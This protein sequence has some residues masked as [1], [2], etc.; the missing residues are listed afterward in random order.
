MA[1]TKESNSNEPPKRPGRKPKMVPAA[2]LKPEKVSLSVSKTL[3]RSAGCLQ[4]LL[5]WAESTLAQIEAGIFVLQ[6]FALYRPIFFVFGFGDQID[7]FITAHLSQLPQGAHVGPR[8]V[9]I[10]PTNT[11]YGVDLVQNDPFL[12]GDEVRL[13][14]RGWIANE[15]AMRRVFP[16]FERTSF[17]QY[18][19]IWQPRASTALGRGDE[20]APGLD[21]AQRAPVPAR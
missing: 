6:V 16:D 7:S 21:P 14:S 9:I 13:L 15:F 1:R 12:R 17:D 5:A 11:F 4:K 18:G 3:T 20:R 2:S 19:E 10:D 8:V